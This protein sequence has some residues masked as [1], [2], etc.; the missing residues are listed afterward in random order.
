[1]PGLDGCLFLVVPATLSSA[2]AVP[3]GLLAYV[4]LGPGQEFIPYFLALLVGAATACLAILQWPFLALR[5][6]LARARGR[7]GDEPKNGS[8]A[9]S[10]PDSPEEGAHD[11]P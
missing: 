6:R 5:R 7:H 11:T 2:L 1:M 10:M 3:F 8:A 9:T 4:G